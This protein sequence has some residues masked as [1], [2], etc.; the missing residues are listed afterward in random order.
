MVEL[1]RI[2]IGRRPIGR[3]LRPRAG[4]VKDG[5]PVPQLRRRQAI[6]D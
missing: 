5:G 3:R 1:E 4:R 2:A 6:A